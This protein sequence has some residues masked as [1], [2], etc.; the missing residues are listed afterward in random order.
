MESA[1]TGN[2]TTI[3]IKKD[4][5]K[6]GHVSIQWGYCESNPIIQVIEHFY[7]QRKKDG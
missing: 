7:K 1:S 5:D 3:R 4:R 6:S 2:T